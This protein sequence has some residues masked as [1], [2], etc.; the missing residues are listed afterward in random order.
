M[1]FTEWLVKLGNGKIV[2]ELDEALGDL[3][4]AAQETG[5]SATIGVAVT[6]KSAGNQ[7]VF[8]PKITANKPSEGLPVTYMFVDRDGNLSDRDPR[9]PRLPGTDPALTVRTERNE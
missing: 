2:R 6:I 5:K 4:L 7:V 8:T 1:R 3:V 9:Q